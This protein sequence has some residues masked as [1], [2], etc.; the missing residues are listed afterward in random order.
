[1]SYE[2]YTLTKT[3]DWKTRFDFLESS[4]YNSV[5][6]KIVGARE[7]FLEVRRGYETYL[8]EYDT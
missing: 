4:D 3:D 8:I 5:K 7:N 6:R 2:L 1:M